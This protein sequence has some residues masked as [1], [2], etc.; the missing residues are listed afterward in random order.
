MRP[1]RK[2]TV[3]F[4]C[5][6]V[7]LS[8][9]SSF[10]TAMALHNGPV[11]YNDSGVCGEDVTYRVEDGTLYIQ[12]TGDMYDYFDTDRSRL[13]DIFSFTRVKIASGVTSVGSGA[14]YYSA[15]N[16]S[17]LT[18]VILPD[19]LGKIGENAFALCNNLEGLRLP[20]SLRRIGSGAFSGCVKLEA[21]T[22][23]AGA[24]YVAPDAFAN[25]P[26]LALTDLRVKAARS[27]TATVAA[28]AVTL[29]GQ[30]VDNAAA[31]YPLLVYQDITYVPMTWDLCRFLGLE[32]RWDGE[33][34]TL[35]IDRSGE[36]GPYVADT[37]GALRP[38]QAVAART[39]DYVVVVG[40][41]TVSGGDT[42]WPLLSF[43]NVTYF[44]LT[45]RYAVESFG[46]DYAWDAENGLRI[47]S[48]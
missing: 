19:T 35:S 26:G 25:C 41:E 14:F 44:P 21:V 18:E 46:W 36:R 20:E 17:P 8:L 12:G 15:G 40:G 13:W 34:R 1:C 5:L 9:L 39:V 37:G 33:T 11:S 2:L 27:V 38:G 23:P 29:N 47:V 4:C 42:D 43:R 45:W 3:I 28:G 10:S 6:L 7:A 31:R 30:A 32:T 22:I 24:I 48:N 16:G